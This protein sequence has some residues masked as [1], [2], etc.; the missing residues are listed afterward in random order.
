MLS[1]RFIYLAARLAWQ[2]M[3]E[4]RI[5]DMRVTETRPWC[6]VKSGPV[7]CSLVIII[8]NM[9]NSLQNGC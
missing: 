5:I 7:F 8:K 9:E 6:M 4:R 2:W 3:K 1:A